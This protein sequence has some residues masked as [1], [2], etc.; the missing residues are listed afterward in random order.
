MDK[1]NPGIEPSLF[2]DD[3]NSEQYQNPLWLKG[4]ESES[5]KKSTFFL[6][7]DKLFE[8]PLINRRKKRDA[9]TQKHYKIFPDRLESYKV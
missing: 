1:L 6:S 5:F 9:I 4:D 8:G 3:I 7:S 2:D